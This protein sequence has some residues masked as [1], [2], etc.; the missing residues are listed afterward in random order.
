M[1]KELEMIDEVIIKPEWVKD[2]E[3]KSKSLGVLNNSISKGQGNVLGFIGE[4]AALSLLKEGHMSNTY[5][6]DIQTPTST[7]DVK[8]KRCKY[9]PKPHYMCTIA[10][11]NTKQRCSHYVFVRMLSDYSKCWVCGWIQ[12][13][14]YFNDAKFLKRG[15]EDGDNGFIIKADCYN[16]PINKLNE[17]E[18]FS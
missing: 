15:E 4:Y 5:D 14:K 13:K 9:K 8:T 12:K 1:K 2:A 10:A 6:Y 17:I 18:F 16:L 7:I 3:A 11:Y